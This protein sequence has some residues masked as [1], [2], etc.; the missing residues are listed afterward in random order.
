MEVTNYSRNLYGPRGV[1]HLGSGGD[2]DD[3]DDDD[4]GENE[5][6]EVTPSY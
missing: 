4:N 6:L 1:A 2:D 5:D 3:D